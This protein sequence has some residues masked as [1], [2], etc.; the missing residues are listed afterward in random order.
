MAMGWSKLP[1]SVSRT[2][3]FPRSGAGAALAEVGVPPAGVVVAASEPGAGEAG[4]AVVPA[5]AGGEVSDPAVPS[6]LSELEHAASRRS[7]TTVA[8]R[9]R[10]MPQPAP[11]GRRHASLR[12]RPG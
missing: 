11:R 6:E 10:A 1:I 3:T 2:A 5:A 8:G 4:G 12:G 7:A 9:A